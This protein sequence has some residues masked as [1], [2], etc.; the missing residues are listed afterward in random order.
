ETS[1]NDRDPAG[2]VY[3]GGNKPSRRLEIGQQG[4]P[5]ADLLKVIDGKRHSGFARNCEQVQHRVGGA[6]SAGNPRNSILKCRTSKNIFRA[7]SPF[8]GLQND[9]TATEGDII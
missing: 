2:F 5:L 7:N 1:G 9:L 4:S 3:I 6:P 8:Q